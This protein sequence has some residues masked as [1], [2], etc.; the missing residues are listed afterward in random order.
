[1]KR[2]AGNDLLDKNACTA[3]VA[4]YLHN[5]LQ[6]VDWDAVKKI[7]LTAGAHREYAEWLCSKFGLTMSVGT[8][9]GREASYENGH[10]TH[11]RDS[12]GYE[13]W[14]KC[15]ADGNQT[16]FR[17][18]DGLETWRE[19]DADGKL[20]HFRKSNG[21]EEWQEYDGGILI[22]ATVKGYEPETLD[23]SVLEQLGI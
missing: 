12:N 15:D 20:T 7:E 16:H 6:D 17:A 1:M 2:I 11:S 8:A 22:S 10:E 14:Q 9:D 13:R 19:Y 21:Y 3:G 18:P 5:R 4:F 23:D